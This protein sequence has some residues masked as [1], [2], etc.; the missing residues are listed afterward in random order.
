MESNVERIANI[1]EIDISINE[2]TQSTDSLAVAMVQRS[3]SATKNY[4]N[5]LE[6]RKLIFK[7]EGNI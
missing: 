7:K 3:E 4:N 5:I 1:S 2:T 6:L